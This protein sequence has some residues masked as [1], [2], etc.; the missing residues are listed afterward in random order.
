MDYLQDRVN[1]LVEYIINY[2]SP[3]WDS[4][5][6]KITRQEAEIIAGKLISDWV[7]NKIC[8]DDMRDYGI[9]ILS[10]RVPE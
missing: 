3:K 8:S 4:N 6:Q 7:T 9:K 1:G 2:K 10:N 5:V